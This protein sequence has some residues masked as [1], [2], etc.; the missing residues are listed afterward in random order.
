MIYCKTHYLTK[1]FL[2][3]KLP[4]KRILN[5]DA[6]FYCFF[7]SFSSLYSSCDEA[8]LNL[9]A[10][11]DI[12]NQSRKSGNAERRSDGSPVRGMLTGKGLDTNRQSP[13]GWIWNK[14]VGKHELIP[15]LKIG[16]YS[17]CRNCGLHQWKNDSEKGSAEWAS[18]N[19]CC[20][21]QRGGNLNH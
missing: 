1:I 19:P 10:K 4:L 16:I 20:L 2:S 11:E 17:H 14:Y 12:K 6:I 13:V 15:A 5:Q 7:I 9:P 8:F 18:V 3:R 21:I